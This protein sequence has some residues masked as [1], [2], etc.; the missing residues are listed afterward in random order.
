[1]NL[2]M[3]PFYFIRHGET[4]WN[5]EGRLQ[6]HTDI[7]LNDKGINQAM[8][9]AQSLTNFDILQIVSSP[10]QRALQTAQI[11][12]DHLNIP[13]TIDE[14]L[15]ECS[16]GVMEGNK[17]E[18]FSF[19]TWLSGKTPKNAESYED[20][21]KRVLKTLNKILTSN[22]KVLVVAHGGVF[23]ALMDILCKEKRKTSNCIPYFFQ[24]FDEKKSIWQAFAAKDL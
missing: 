2:P 17:K 15:K 10:L 21:K 13:Y 23:A 12:G 20:F 24:P 19:E 3:I 16:Y 11:I 14:G 6:G 4:F 18:L 7:P 9:A 8:Q 1:M 5:F 22:D